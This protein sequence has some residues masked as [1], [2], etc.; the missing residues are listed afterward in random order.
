VPFVSGWI[1]DRLG[2][3]HTLAG[4]FTLSGLITILLGIAP[5]SWVIAVLFIQPVVAVCFFPAGFAAISSIG[6]PSQRNYAVSLTSASS[7]LLGAGIVPVGLGILG[8]NASFA[9]GI[10]LAGGVMIAGAFLA[11]RLHFTDI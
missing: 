1:T 6:S 3:K 10:S 9:L 4:I 2:A 11:L 7:L 8:E 5:D